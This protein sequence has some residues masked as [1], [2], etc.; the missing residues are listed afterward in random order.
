MEIVI[1]STLISLGDGHHPYT[2][3]AIHYVTYILYSIIFCFL[4]AVTV[5][6]V[7]PY[8]TGSGIPE[9][10]SIL[11]GVHIPHYLS[12]STLV[13]KILGLICAFAGGL[14]I[15]KEGPYVHIS[16][17]IADYVMR[18]PLWNKL[19]K[20][21]ALRFQIISAACA[22]GVSTSFGSPI[23]GVLFSVEVTSS[24]YMV[25][26][27]WKG[28]WCAMCGALVIRLL[29][30]FGFQ[31]GLISLFR[32]NDSEFATVDLYDWQELI[33]FALVGIT[34]GLIGAAF[35]KV[36]RWLIAATAQIKF[37]EQVNGSIV[38]A[39]IIGLIVALLTYPFPLIR[40]DQQGID[41]VFDSS[42]KNLD[43]IPFLLGMVV[44]KFI[45]TAISQLAGLSCGVYTP[46]FVLGAAYGRLIG[47]IIAY[48]V[49]NEIAPL[50]YAVVG[51][52][53][54]CGSATHTI[55]TAVIIV[56]LTGQFHLLLPI[57]L[58]VLL[59]DG[60]AKLL[61]PSIYDEL[62]FQKGL[63]YMPSFVVGSS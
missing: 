18:F 19:P 49:P 39:C 10:K 13:A 21:Q 58:S 46:L 56:E 17:I 23:G 57:L 8:S 6:L 47:E 25:E 32:L 2:A 62:L 36:T 53:A 16:S 12:F 27:L 31:V 30:E 37:L 34:G 7:S 41:Y 22:V 60:I 61:S 3:F 28:F 14:S 51:A 52:A 43:Q 33:I 40:N 29:A 55:S 59:A 44:I 35:V 50:S 9:M 11:S 38:R 15:G 4:S 20:N 54:V 45:I 24:Y 42:Q 5:I 48:F 1:E 63:P 26:N